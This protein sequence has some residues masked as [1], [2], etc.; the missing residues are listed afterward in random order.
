MSE[1]I[2]DVIL[3][4]P[5]HIE[6]EE[7]LLACM[8]MEIDCLEKALESLN[9][10]DFYSASN[11]TIFNAILNLHKKEI[12]IDLITLNNELESTNLLESIG[13]VQKLSI[14]SSSLHT[15]A[16]FKSYLNT[17]LEKGQL[18]K[19]ISI[20]QKS[21][22]MAM[23]GKEES[24]SILDF[25]SKETSTL[26]TQYKNEDFENISSISVRVVEK[27]EQLS[28]SK[29]DITG[30]STG[31]RDL[32]K[33]TAGLQ[34]G[35]LVLIAARP[36]MGKTSLALNIAQ[37]VALSGKTVAFFSLEMSKEELVSRIISSCADIDSQRAR[38]GDLLDTDWE[39]LA[40]SIGPISRAKMYIDDTAGITIS[41][42]KSRARKLKKEH[43]LD[44][45][46]I[47]YLQ[48]MSSN[49]RSENRQQVISEISRELKILSK[50]LEVPVIALSQL[51]RASEQRT[52]NHRPILSD[53]RESGAIEQDA[54]IVSFIYRDEYYNPQT[55]EPGVS[56]LIIAKHRAGSVGTIKLSW[57][58]ETTTFN[59]LDFRNTDI[60]A[61]YE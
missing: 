5:S 19:I 33:Y 24:Y 29:K 27:L 18:R 6:S 56:E 53:L 2:K 37:N 32:D 4:T 42:I 47:D 7:A 50:E 16:N 28:L 9:D 54:D 45:I 31:F 22:Q 44:I 60:P 17:V 41:E 25:I 13:G 58:A 46:F 10:L 43:G 20:S 8:I 40:E 35:T 23:D 52:G 15:T 48:I 1:E 12:A 39:K 57:K 61:N 38:I 59:D 55:L 26:Q 49:S 3:K 34:K 36:A 30:L 14:I 21:I 51:S 11:R